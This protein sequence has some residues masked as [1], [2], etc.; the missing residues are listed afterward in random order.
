MKAVAYVRVSTDEQ[1][2]DGCSLAAQREKVD[3]YCRLHDLELIDVCE[4]AGVSGKR[5]DNRPGLQRAL[6]LA[7]K[8]KAT[9]VVYS[10]SRLARSVRDCIDISER[11]SKCGATLASL[12][13]RLDTSSAAGEFFFNI[14]ASLAQMERKQI[15]ER[16]RLGMDYK[17]RR[18]ERIGTV[19]IGYRVAADGVQLLPDAAGQRDI[20][21][22]R[23]L[24]ADGLSYAAITDAMNARG[25]RRWYL[26]TVF[27]VLKRAA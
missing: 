3:A 9:L 15:G 11:I 5:A 21:A 24:R 25:G 1:A 23:K 13:E 6:A 14:M 26:K 22:M 8:H 27:A 2:A 20:A 10:L 16:T 17:R 7:C 12:S 19:P 18:H 4:D